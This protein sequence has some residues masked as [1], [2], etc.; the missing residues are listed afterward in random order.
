MTGLSPWALET[1]SQFDV[2]LCREGIPCRGNPLWLPTSGQAQGPAPTSVIPR[3]DVPRNP[4]TSFGVP[5]RRDPLK[6]D[7]AST[8]NDPVNVI[9]TQSVSLGMTKRRAQ[10][11]SLFYLSW[12]ECEASHKKALNASSNIFETPI[13]KRDYPKIA[14]YRYWR[15]LSPVTLAVD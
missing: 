6:R 4:S 10:S 15:R 8:M 7:V 3:H 1:V 14:G 2:R 13:G 5:Y 11:D 9:M 12:N